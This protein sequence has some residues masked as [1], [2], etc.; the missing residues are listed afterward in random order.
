MS[1]SYFALDTSQI[2]FEDRSTVCYNEATA[3]PIFL[4]QKKIGVHWDTECV[5]YSREEGELFGNKF[6]YNYRSGWRVYCV[7]CG[8]VLQD[9]LRNFNPRQ[10]VKL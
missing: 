6:A 7:P 1:Y 9:L 8:G 4:F 5:F 3:N 2:E 10:E